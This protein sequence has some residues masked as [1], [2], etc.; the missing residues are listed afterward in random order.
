MNIA[1]G[2]LHLST[3]EN[4]GDGP[5]CLVGFTRRL[6]IDLPRLPEPLPLPTAMLV[7][8]FLNRLNPFRRK[9]RLGNPAQPPVVCAIL[10]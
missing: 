1:N 5:V 6:Q 2:E 4:L 7:N 10:E 9:E 8:H 3:L